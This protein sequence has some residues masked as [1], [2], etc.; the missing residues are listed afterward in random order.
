MDL[1]QTILNAQGGRA[2]DA[3][4]QQVGL[5]RNQTMAALQ[6]LLPALAGGLA[7]NASQPGGLESLESALTRGGHTRYLDNPAVLGQPE[8]IQDG[9]GILG[10]LLGSKDVS[11]QVASNVSTQ[12]GL[13]ADVLKKMLPMVASLAMAALA[14]RAA[15]T[16][17]G[18]VQLG[19]DRA[20]AG[21]FDMLG[22]LLG[23]GQNAGGAIGGILGS[24]FRK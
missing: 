11:R 12:T 4:G 23:G 6:G 13:G 8:A 3:M 14:Q 22:P 16:P 21:L 20:G 19:Q 10:H 7:K 15:R 18:N 9:N 17:S 24:M 5:D 2:V 1:L